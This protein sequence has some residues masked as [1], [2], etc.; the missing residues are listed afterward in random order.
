MACINE[1]FLPDGYVC[2]D[3]YGVNSFLS[4]WVDKRSCLSF[5]ISVVFSNSD[6]YSPTGTLTV[7]TS[8]AKEQYGAVLGGAKG[9][10]T[11]DASVFPGAS[12]AISAVGINKFDIQTPDRL[13]RVRYVSSVDVAG[14]TVYVV[15]SGPKSTD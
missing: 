15:G 3:G 5:G 12:V 1:L 11:S 9:L 2:S 4:N 14:L 7:E 13:I 6:G 8:N 10:N